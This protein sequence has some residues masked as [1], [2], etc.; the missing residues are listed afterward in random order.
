V[1]P[2]TDYPQRVDASLL[3][4]LSLCRR[5][6][7]TEFNA[8]PR[9]RVA[10]V[11]ETS[12]SYARGVLRGINRY[13][14]EHRPWAIYLPDQGCGDTPPAWLNRWKG[15]GLIVRIEHRSLIKT[16]QRLAL[17]TVNISTSLEHS[18]S[19]APRVGTDAAPVS[20]AGFD[21]LVERGFRRFG[22][23]GDSRFAWSVARETAFCKFA[24]DAGYPCEVYHQRPSSRGGA[25][26]QDQA[27]LI[28]WIGGL[29]RPIGLMA[30]ND[31]RGQQV[32]EAGRQIGVA[33]P[34]EIAVIGVDNDELLCE[35]SQPSLSSVIPDVASIGYQ[36]AELLDRMLSGEVVAPDDIWL[37][38]LGVVTRQST[39]AFAVTDPD[40]V[41]ALQFIRQHACEGIKVGSVVRELSVSRRILEHRFRRLLGCTPHEQII[42]VQLQRVRQ[43]LAETDLPLAA[44]ADLAGF[45]H[46]EY[47]SVAFRRHAGVTPRDYRLRR[48]NR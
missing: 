23:C 47:L 27:D 13:V 26:E 18:K 19:L 14:R 12:S 35:L 34:D 17:P 31:I 2:L 15:D 6:A 25:G 3:I 10:L 42:R 48:Q 7:I 36:A 30:C 1:A 9:F 4:S 41:R 20:K 45:K 21:H 44:I 38:P 11:I 24:N 32:L 5:S 46:V 39:D 29:P 28:R 40:V 8:K 33:A 37:P 22:F 16:I 43:L